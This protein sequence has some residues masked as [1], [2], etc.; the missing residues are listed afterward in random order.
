METVYDLSK[1]ENVSMAGVYR[2][3]NIADADDV[4]D[5]LDRMKIKQ[6]AYTPSED[7]DAYNILRYDKNGLSRDRVESVGL[8]RSVVYKNGKI[9]CFSPPKALPNDKFMEMHPNPEECVAEEFIEGT[10][11]NVFFDNSVGVTG[12][13]V[14]DWEISTKSTVGARVSFFRDGEV[15][16]DETFRYMFLEAAGVRGLEFDPGLRKDY[17]YSFVLQHPKNRIVTPFTEMEIYLIACYNI[18][19]KSYCVTS[20]PIREVKDLFKN[21][22]VK[23]PKEVQFGSYE[24]VREMW[25][26]GNIDYKEMGV[27]IKHKMSGDRMKIRNPN[28]EL[29]RKLRGNQPKLQYRY[30]VLRSEG[31]VG[32]YL[33]YFPEAREQFNMFRDQVHNF[34]QQLCNN[35]RSCYIKKAKP[36]I[37]YPS[38]Y[39]MHMFTLHQD[40][41]S[42]LREANQFVNK[43]YVIEYVNK[44]HP[45][46]LM[47]SINFSMR[48]RQV[49]TEIA[50]QEG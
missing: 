39:R 2:A 27:V 41:L 12:R 28:Y 22:D 23:Y 50:V 3:D 7:S 38:Q 9:L 30:M 14:N 47:F 4:S 33:H 15:K 40:Y 34:T 25:E 6:T 29:V 43:Q 31:K 32:E 13:V 36:L 18:D 20:V 1:I 8:F 45:S 26:S 19:T 11:I 16:H 42:T 21:T 44:L 49:E 35:Y 48:R 46:K 5:I 17:C 24:G 10:M 37:Q